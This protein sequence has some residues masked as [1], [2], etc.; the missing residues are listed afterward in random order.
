MSNNPT[1]LS[2]AD[3]TATFTDGPGRTYTA[4]GFTTGPG[5]FVAVEVGTDGVW[6]T[7]G[8]DRYPLRH[9]NDPHPTEMTI[10]SWPPNPYLPV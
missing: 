9:G 2:I 6:L 5:D 10:M 4:T 8:E 1:A 3:G 7:V